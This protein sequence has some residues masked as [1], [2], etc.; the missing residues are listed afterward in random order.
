MPNID[1]RPFGGP[2][3]ARGVYGNPANPL[4]WQHQPGDHSDTGILPLLTPVSGSGGVTFGFSTSGTGTETFTGT[5]GV[6]FG[7]STSGTG[8]ETF[9]GSGGVTFG[10]ST[11]A[12]GTATVAA[13]TTFCDYD[14]AGDTY[15]NAADTYDCSGVPDTGPQDWFPGPLLTST[16]I[17]DDGDLLL[18]VAVL[19]SR[20]RL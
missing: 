9:T 2:S 7:F 3:Y 17:T 10:F 8:T 19:R 11:S 4:E 6:T 16:P 12:T 14:F 13:D 1:P 5:G 18:A 20:L 15:D